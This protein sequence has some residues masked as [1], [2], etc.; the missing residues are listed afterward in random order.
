MDA[1]QPRKKNNYSYRSITKCTWSTL[2]I[3]FSPMAYVP[4]LHFS[5]MSCHKIRLRWRYTHLTVR[6]LRRAMCASA[7]YLRSCARYAAGNAHDKLRNAH[8][9]LWNAHGM[10]RTHARR[11]PAELRT[12][13]CG[14]CAR[15]AAAMRTISCG[16]VFN[17]QFGHI[18]WLY[19][20]QF[21]IKKPDHVHWGYIHYSFTS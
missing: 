16:P 21:D 10:M 2:S 14:K 6:K 3:V 13:C 9:M 8:Y 12:I 15:Y 19:G 1:G 7:G 11:V 17:F 18:C 5:P 20:S 4:S